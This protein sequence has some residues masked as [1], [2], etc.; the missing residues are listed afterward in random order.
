M[1][2]RETTLDRVKE[3]LSRY[4]DREK[5]RAQDLPTRRLLGWWV[6]LSHRYPNV[7]VVAQ[8]NLGHTASSA[9]IERDFGMAGKL[10]PGQRSRLDTTFVDMSLF[11]NANFEEIPA[12]VPEMDSSWQSHIPKRFTREETADQISHVPGNVMEDSSEE[13]DKD[14][15]LWD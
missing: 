9:Q 13:S 15:G 4:V 12:T 1:R 11:L 14:A 8:S 7:S 6:A 5:V 10:L 3:E 2:N